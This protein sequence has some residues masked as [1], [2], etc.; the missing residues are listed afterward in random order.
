MLWRAF[1]G[2]LKEIL[3]FVKVSLYMFISTTEPFSVWDQRPSPFVNKQITWFNQVGGLKRK[4]AMKGI[5]SE[6]ITFG[7]VAGKCLFHK[8]GIREKL[9]SGGHLDITYKFYDKILRR[10]EDKSMVFKV[11]FITLKVGMHLT[12]IDAESSAN[13]H[14]DI[15]TPTPNLKGWHFP[16][17]AIKISYQIL[18]RPLLLH[19]F[20]P[21]T[22]EIN[23][24]LS[25]RWKTDPC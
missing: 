16:N 24:L 13:F 8:Y 25:Q 9:S 12:S 5:Y 20:S 2:I 17:F 14:S 1:R 21:N 3:S 18:K 23:T 11:F 22:P 10:F 15:G 7:S 6:Q 4:I 19:T